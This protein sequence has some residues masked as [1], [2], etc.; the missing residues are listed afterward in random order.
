MTVTEEHIIRPGVVRGDYIDGLNA[1]TDARAEELR[2]RLA[3]HVRALVPA[4]ESCMPD[5][6]P[7]RREQAEHCLRQAAETLDASPSA[8]GAIACTY[9]L[10]VSAR[11]LLVLYRRPGE[12]E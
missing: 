5:M 9:D 1:T 7:R 4:V 6:S 3:Q 2:E 10:A 12:P 11:A 8:G